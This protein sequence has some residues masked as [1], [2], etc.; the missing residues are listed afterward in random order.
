[1]LIGLLIF[2]LTCVA[3]TRY[4]EKRRMYIAN[5][6]YTVTF[7]VVL[8]TVLLSTDQLFLATAM[9]NMFGKAYPFLHEVAREV[10][11]SPVLGMNLFG[12]I[13]LIFAVQSA[14]TVVGAVNVV[15]ASF[16]KEVLA[17]K[18]KKIY[19]AR[20]SHVIRLRMSRSINLLYCRMLT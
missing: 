15:K 19:V 18:F 1:M 3:T 12:V 9:Q 16:R 4:L 20:V 8:T 17:R 7:V 11:N 2:L 5:V 13:L 10:M 6:L 14:A